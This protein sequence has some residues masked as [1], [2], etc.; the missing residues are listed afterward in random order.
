ME[1]REVSE[2]PEIFC[3]CLGLGW[4]GER[5]ERVHGCHQF[6]VVPATKG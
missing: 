3:M 6:K 2:P 5:E 4:G 1:F